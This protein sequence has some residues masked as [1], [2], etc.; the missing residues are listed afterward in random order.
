MRLLF[1]TGAALALF[2]TN[3]SAQTN[4]KPAGTGLPNFEFKGV[5]AGEP[6]DMSIMTDCKPDDGLTRCYGRDPNVA[7]VRLI[8]APSYYFLNGKLS[9][10]LFLF[11]AP[12]FSTMAQAFSTKYG[13]P[14]RTTHPKW[15]S[16]AG[17]VFEN[18]VMTWC[19]RTG[20]L[21]L[22]AMSS[23]RDYGHAQYVDKV[24]KLP[25]KPATVDF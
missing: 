16:K 3:A 17:A 21:E 18:T 1:V 4:A 25:P 19:F 10:M 9:M 7:G 8:L 23:S 20:E 15:Q 12:Q 11:N 5:R 2:A 24:V 6:A 13:P 22:A 14:C